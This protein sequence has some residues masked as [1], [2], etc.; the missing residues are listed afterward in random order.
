MWRKKYCIFSVQG[1]YI[2]WIAYVGL[3]I[4]D[5]ILISKKIFLF[6]WYLYILF[7]YF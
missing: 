6:A 3:H 7:L 2:L 4:N 5:R 1:T